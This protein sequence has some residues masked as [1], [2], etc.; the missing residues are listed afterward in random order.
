VSI[1]CITQTLLYFPGL[2]LSTDSLLVAGARAVAL[3]MHTWWPFIL[4]GLLRISSNAARLLI[5]RPCTCMAVDVMSNIIMGCQGS[6]AAS[7]IVLECLDGFQ[8]GLFAVHVGHPM[9]PFL[10]N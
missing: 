2:V 3:D 6:W 7:V 9:C 4:L 1:T 8:N 10:K 5:H